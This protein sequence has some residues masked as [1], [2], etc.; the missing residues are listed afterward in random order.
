[1]AEAL[2]VVSVVASIIQLLDF[3]TKVVSRLNEFYSVAKEVPKSFRHVKTEL[4]LLA[5]TLAQLKDA[6]DTTS[7]VD[8]ATKA[9]VPVI[10]GCAE[11]VEKLDAILKNVLPKNNDSLRIKGKKAIVSLHM[12]HKVQSITETLRN[13][14]AILTFYYAAASSTLQPLT[15]RVLLKSSHTVQTDSPIDAKLCKMR[16]WLS[17]PDPSTNYQKALKLRQANTGSWLLECD[18]Y[19]EWKRSVTT[20]LWLYG[21]P[22]CGKTILSSTILENVLQ[23]CQD[24]PGKV[25]AYFFF[26]FNNALKQDP[27]IMLCS[28]LC[29]LSEQAI[30]IP[31]SLDALFSSCQ[32]GQR[33]PSTDAL[34]NALQ[35][36]TQDFPQTYIL[37]DAL[38]ECTQRGELM[39]MLETIMGW[40]E[41]NLHLVV[42][43]RRE[44][45]IE[46]SLVKS[47]DSQNQ[48]CLQ[49]AIVDKDIQRYVRQRLSKDR[50]LQKWEKDASTK[51]QIE[52]VLMSGA[53]GMYVH[54]TGSL[55]YCSLIMLLGFGG[56]F[57]SWTN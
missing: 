22:G 24:D 56:L 9:L 50:R 42:T 3:S 47:V 8:G 26:D 46:S 43:S 57:A 51:A 6:L 55:S 29:Q 49:S 27:E 5:T 12:D 34:M 18:A 23:H 15:G 33:Q 20:P 39:E 19:T 30:K 52:S 13:Y 48:I 54:S 35:S 10:A 2:A 1:M 31:P 45:D 36:I 38:D 4:P 53:K 37:L 11:E 28:L 25:T 7:A 41:P 17:A 16:Q 14:V 21:I 32:D 40:K 44:H